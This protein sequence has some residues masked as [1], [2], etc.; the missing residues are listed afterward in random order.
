V[1]VNSL[2]TWFL[3]LFSGPKD[4]LRLRDYPVFAKLS[5]YDLYLLSERIHERSFS[6]GEVIFEAQYPLEVI[7]FIR[8]GEIK[9]EGMYG[10]SQEKILGQMEHL[11]ILD[12]FHGDSRTGTATAATDVQVDAIAKSDLMDYIDAR[13]RCGL[14][15]YH[16]ICQDFASFIFGSLN[17]K[18]DELD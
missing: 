16:A 4:Y 3:S 15:I 12:M 13:P 9:L 11:G 6:L 1:I 18:S 8:S 14:K 7:Y 2:W 10:G 17:Q 5:S